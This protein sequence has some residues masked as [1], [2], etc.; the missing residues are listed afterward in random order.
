M[1]Q[2]KIFNLITDKNYLEDLFNK[3]IADI[4]QDGFKVLRIQSYYIKQ[5]IDSNF[6]HFVIQHNIAIETRK[7]IRRRYKIYCVSFSHHERRKM[8][9]V[10]QL[11]YAHG[12]DKGDVIVPRPLWY[13]DELMAAFYVGV[14]GE[15]LLEHIKNGYSSLNT[16]RKISQG[17]SNFHGIAPPKSFKLTRHNF[18]PKYL[19]PTNIINR[20]YNRN[21]RLATEV[22][23]QYKKLK[24]AYKKIINKNEYYLSHGDF[25]PENVIVNKFN[26]RQIAL[27]DFSEV[28][29]APVYFDIGSFLQQLQFMTLNYL[30]PEQYQQIEYIFCSTYFNK[31]KLPLEI[32]NKLNLYKSWTALKSTVYFMIFEDE[33]NRNFARYLLT[34]SEDFYRQIKLK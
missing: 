26:N 20:P 12:F 30:T 23:V 18:S 10:L 7:N 11:A 22:V 33:I 4:D 32:K 24:I 8:F 19:D 21:T 9:Q 27:I 6:F 3:H 5:H 29:L 1:A 25:H 34:Q 16:I 17:L 31:K 2:N 15:N 28:G 13:I 14:P